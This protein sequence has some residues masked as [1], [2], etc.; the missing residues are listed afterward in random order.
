MKFDFEPELAFFLGDF[1]EPIA[2]G[3]NT[4]VCLFDFKHDPLAFNAGGRSI[5]A[6]VQA[7]DFVGVQQGDVVTIRFQDFSIAEIHVIQRG[8][9]LRFN[10]EQL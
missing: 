5:E 4:Y 3:G 10:L 6:V 2:W 8:D 1:G 7:E 9:F